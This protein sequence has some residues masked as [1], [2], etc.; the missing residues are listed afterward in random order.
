MKETKQKQPAGNVTQLILTLLLV[1]AAFAIG[2]MWTELKMLKSRSA[3]L[4]QEERAA[5]E[6]AAAQPEDQPLT[7]EIWGEVVGQAAPPAGEPEVTDS[8]TGQTEAPPPYSEGSETAAVTLVEFTDYQCPFCK[9]HFDQTEEQLQTEYIKTG[10]VRWIVRDLPLSFHQNA[11]L[12]AQAARCA[13]DQDQYKAMRDKLFTNQTVW[14]ESAEARPLFT[15]YAKNLG[16]DGAAFDQCLSSGK[17]KAAVEADLELA[18]KAGANGT[19]TF[20]INGTP[21][22]GAQPFAAF[23][24]AIEAAL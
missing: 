19:P 8:G 10:K 11:H 24:E 23:K 6:P 18:A 9:R 20:F 17:H 13:G 22:V 2:S 14:G 1:G 15:G 3:G 4:V 12:A 7:E 16:L 21:L 5:G